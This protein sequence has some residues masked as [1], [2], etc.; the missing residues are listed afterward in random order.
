M[1]QLYKVKLSESE[2]KQ[3]IKLVNNGSEKAKK[4]L[5]A[6]ILLQ[7]DCS[8]NG[9]GK[10]AKEIAKI[11][12]I[13]DR[14]VHRVRHKFATRGLEVALN[15]KEHEA[16][17]PRKI[18]GEKEARLI[19]ICCSEAP[20]GRKEW[21]LKL[22][23]QKLVELDIVENISRS[24]VCRA[25]K[26]TNLNHGKKKNGVSRPAVRNSCAEWKTS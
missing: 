5:H 21:T 19:S 17:K 7:A 9:P 6:R 14:T 18:D 1:K 3:L 25:L 22:L 15:R 20:E 2:R 8:K 23:S 11:L 12:N 16:Y 26:K 13:S 4:T 10:K 24:T